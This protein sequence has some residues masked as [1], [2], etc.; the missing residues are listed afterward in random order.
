MRQFT[1]TVNKVSYDVEVTEKGVTV[2]PAPAAVQAPRESAPAAQR[3]VPVAAPAPAPAAPKATAPASGGGR[4]IGAPMPGR[5][6]AVNVKAGDTV[7]KGDVLLILEAMKM[8]NEIAVPED[9]VVAD[10]CVKANQTV[11]SGDPMVVLN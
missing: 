7:K 8:Q 9:A 5:I 6:V 10:V 11:A 2:A 4:V 3:P 1:V